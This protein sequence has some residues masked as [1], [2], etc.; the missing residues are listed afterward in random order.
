VVALQ[1]RGIHLDEQIPRRI[2]WSRA[3]R[4][5]DGRTQAKCPQHQ[6]MMTPTQF[7]TL[8]FI[9]GLALNVV[10]GAFAA[11]TAPASPEEAQTMSDCP[12]GPPNG[13]AGAAKGQAGERCTGVDGAAEESA[14]DP[15]TSQQSGA[16]PAENR[17]ESSLAI[18]ENAQGAY[19]LRKL[20]LGRQFQV[21]GR[22]E[23]DIAI[24][25]YV[26]YF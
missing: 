18:A 21:F 13:A 3:A 5:Q 19:L 6:A 17:Q 4:T 20:L 23:G 2:G 12:I 11:T 9:A 22:V 1:W 15:D 10:P 25:V 26:T 14:D 8:L 16:L 24:A 7:V